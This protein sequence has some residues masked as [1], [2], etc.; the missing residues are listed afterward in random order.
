[1]LAWTVTFSLDAGHRAVY[2]LQNPP[3]FFFA[4]ALFGLSDGF[5]WQGLFLLYHY[6]GCELILGRKDQILIICRGLLHNH[7]LSSSFICNFISD[8]NSHNSG[9]VQQPSFVSSFILYKWNTQ[10]VN[11]DDCDFI[12][13]NMEYYQLWIN[14]VTIV[15]VSKHQFNSI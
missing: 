11:I 12:I 1:M 5:S 13:V 2:N 8:K 14:N 4:F 6:I 9:R 10:V 3:P 7:L 15:L